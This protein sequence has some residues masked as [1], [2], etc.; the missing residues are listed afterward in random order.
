MDKIKN[1]FSSQ[2]FSMNSFYE[3]FIPRLEAYEEAEHDREK[4]TK[5]QDMLIEHTE[6]VYNVFSLDNTS[7]IQSNLPR[8]PRRI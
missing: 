3:Q 2:G 1:F 8:Y 5:T 7:H 4:S 6:R